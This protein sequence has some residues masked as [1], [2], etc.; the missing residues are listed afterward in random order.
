MPNQKMPQTPETYDNM[1][2]DGGG[3]QV[4]RQHYRHSCYYPLF[5]SIEKALRQRGLKRVL[6]VGC[7]TGAFAHLLRDRGGYEYQ[8]FDFSPEAVRQA[9]ERTGAHLRFSVSDARNAESYR[10]AAAYDAIVCTE[11]LE[12][13]PEDLEVIASWPP[14]KVVFASVPN[15]DSRYHVR[16]FKDSQ[17]VRA[18]YRDALAIDSITPIKKPYLEDISWSSYWR[19][20]RWARYK[21]VEIA[22]IVGL[23]RVEDVGCWFVLTGVTRA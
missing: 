17:D 9:K 6:E 14:G 16:F 18:R 22:R 3:V 15:F 23:G 5:N 13:V 2:R 4:F 21:P 19:S 20:L 1:F 7:G 8:G 11:V 12:H 10:T